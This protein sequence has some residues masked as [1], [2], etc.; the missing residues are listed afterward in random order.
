MNVELSPEAT[1]FGHEASRA[2]E[3]AGGDQL[4]ERIEQD[5][6]RRSALVEPVLAELGAWDLT[7]RSDPDELEAAAALCRSAGRIT[8]PYP[9]AERLSRPLDLDVDG[10]IVVAD[11]T[12]GPEEV[13]QDIRRQLGL[14]PRKV[15]RDRPSPGVTRGHASGGRG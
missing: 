11:G 6:T 5:P 4:V 10:L 15:V 13:Q 1:D 3:A 2:F 8:L 12:K 9:M 14:P 7:P